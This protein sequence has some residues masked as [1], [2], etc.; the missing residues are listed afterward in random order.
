VVNSLGDAGMGSGAQGDLRYAITQANAHPGSTIEFDVS[1]SIQLTSALPAMTASMNIDGPGPG[2]LTVHGKAAPAS[3]SVFAVSAGVDVSISGL[4]ITGGNAAEGGG[5]NNAGTLTVNNSV[6]AGNTATTDGGAIS[7]SGTLTLVRSALTGN[8]APAGGALANTAG[9]ASLSYDTLSSNSATT[10]GGAIANSA[11]MSVLDST[12]ASNSSG[13]GGGAIQN[14]ATLLLTNSTVWGNTAADKGGGIVNQS[15]N[16]T[17]T[18]DTLSANRATNGFGGGLEDLGAA[19]LLNNTLIA[20]NLAGSSPSTTAGDVDG[21]VNSASSSNLIGDGDHLTGISNGSQGNQIGSASAGTVINARLVPLAGNGG[22][23]TTAA[24]LPTSPALG[25]GSVA[26]AVEPNTGLSLTTDQRGLGF[27]RVVNG[28]VDIGAYESGL[29]SPSGT[30]YTVNSLGDTGSGSGTSGDLRYAITQA[31]ANPGSTI[32]FSV[33]GTIALSSLLPALSAD[34][35]IAGPG[36]TRLTVDGV[37]NAPAT[38]GVFTINA[39][40]SASISNLAIAGLPTGT[41]GSTG[42]DIANAGT[43]VLTNSTLTGTVSPARAALYNT[44]TANATLRNVSITGNH[45][46]SILS[47]GALT[48]LNSSVTGD[49]FTFSGSGNG[50][51][52]YITRGQLTMDGST[53]SGNSVTPNHAEYYHN[54]IRVNQ[55]S[56]TLTNCTI[57]GNSSNASYGYAVSAGYGAQVS[58]T[59]VTIAGNA[60]GGCLSTAVVRLSNATISGN[61]GPGLMIDRGYYLSY[62]VGDVHV[63]LANSLLSG[64]VTKKNSIQKDVVGVVDPK[65]SGNLIASGYATGITNGS[66]GNQIGSQKQGTIINPDLG[67][68]TN[69]GGA[70]QT[71]ALLA[72]S[73]AIDSGLNSAVT[74]TTDS[75][76]TSDQ[77]GPGFSRIVHDTIDI[78][79]YEFQASPT[80]A[81]RLVSLVPVSSSV[82]VNNTFTLVVSAE[83]S[84]GAV[85]VGIVGSVALAL[86]NNPSGAHLGGNLTANFVNGEAVFIGLT[87]DQPGSGY[88]IVASSGGLASAT[89]NAFDV[90]TV[91]ATKLVITVPPPTPIVAGV[92]FNMSVAAEDGLG[93]IDTS[94]DG[95]VSVRAD[96]SDPLMNGNPVYGKTTVAVVNGIAN[97]TGLT[98][99]WANGYGGLDPNTINATSAGLVSAYVDHLDVVPGAATQLVVQ[100]QPPSTVTSEARFGLTVLA[101]DSVGNVDTSFSGNVSIAIASNPS[102]GTLGGTVVVAAANG[103]AVFASSAQQGLY[104]DK[105][106]AGYTLQATSPGLTPVTTS[107]IT[108]NPGAAIRLVTTAEPPAAVNVGQTFG[109][110]VTAEDAGGNPI[111]GYSGFVTVAIANNPGGAILGG[112]VKE[113]AVNGVA[114]FTDLTLDQQGFGY[115]LTASSSGLTSN[116]TSAFDVLGPHTPPTA[117]PQT[118]TLPDSGSA[119]ITLTGSSPVT[120][121]SELVYTLTSLPASGTLY[122]SDGN[123]AFVGETFT[124]SA[125]VL[126]YIL[127]TEVLGD[128]STSF[129]FT[130]T[131][132]GEP[133]G[134]MNTLTSSPA[135]VTIQTPASSTGI[136][137]VFGGPGNDTIVLSQTSGNTNLHVLVNG[138]A[139]GSD[140]PF[141]SVTSIEVTGRDGTNSYTIPAGLPAPISVIGGTGADTLIAGA[142]NLTFNGG[143][144]GDA[145][146]VTLD[147]NA[148]TTTLSPTS[149][150]IT[151]GSDTIT[152]SNVATITVNGNNNATATLNDSPGN[153]TFTASPTFGTMTGPGF[154][155]RANGFAGVTA[156]S[157]AGGSDSAHLSD[158]SGSNTFTATPA[159]ATFSGTGFSESARGFGA[160]YGTAAAGTTDTAT[161]SDA[162]GSNS[163]TGTPTYG[164]FYGTGFYNKGTGFVSVLAKAAAGTADTATLNDS[165]GNDTFTATPT[166]GTMT[167]PGYSNRANGFASLTAISSAGG[168]D[169]AHLS[170]TSGRNTFTATPTSATFGGT[171]FS[172][173]AK[174]FGAVYGTAAAGTTDTATL[175]DVSGTN[176]F[177]GTPTYGLFDGAGFYDKASGF[178]EVLAKAAA[179]TTDTATLSDTSGTNLLSADPDLVWL[180]GS[181][182]FNT[183]SR[184]SSVVANSAAGTT[185]SAYLDDS[186]GNDTFTATPTSA[187]MTGPGYWNRANGFKSSAAFSRRGGTDSAHLSDTSGRNTFTAYPTYALFSGNGFSEEANGFVTVYGTATAGTTDT[188]TL[189]DW[190]GSN[191]FAGTPTSGLFYGT[192]F[193]IKAAGFV[194]VRATAV[195]GTTDSATLNDSSG[196]D[197][198]TAGPTSATMTGPGYSNLAIGFKS[199]TAISSAGGT[200]SAHLSDK[201]GS[202]TFTATPTTATFS[203]SGFSETAKGF[204]AMYGTAAAGTTDTATLSDASGS[205]T[206][207]GTPTSGLFYGTGFYNK[208]AG[209]VSVVA[210][211]AAGTTDSA[212]LNDSSGNDTFTAGPTFGTMTGPGYSNRANG[213]AS[214][215]AVSSAGGTDSAHLSDTSG[216]N[217]FTATQ[218]SATFRGTGFA[219]TAKGFGAVYGTAAAGTTDTASLTDSSGS[220]IFTGTPTSGLFYGTGFYNKASGFVTV[221]ATAAHNSDVANLSDD[222]AGAQFNGTGKVGTLAGPTYTLNVTAYGTVNITGAS[223]ASNKV[224]TA[225]IDYVLNKIGTWTAD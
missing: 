26:L 140:V 143:G 50:G 106:G 88:T 3:F 85:D 201:S 197:T 139:P 16:L 222:A 219:L 196:N 60:E 121:G 107:S 127:P 74:L 179:G 61:Q 177:T 41:S 51:N 98:M 63:L 64:N 202:N 71:Q 176:T 191:H 169:S 68:L 4:T 133:D 6:L 81:T 138:N 89:T 117:N 172:N 186:S 209:F 96:N 221:S 187:T 111:A 97:F 102:G 52:I 182:Y 92:G 216:S 13:G 198:F 27:A 199:V 183:V 118:V 124:G 83:D 58:M 14:S 37:P 36:A 93:H 155:E 44:D 5:I 59:N 152:L 151:D 218:T 10:T 135:T 131:D 22:P 94:Y 65:S 40:V 212:T 184:F 203:G 32:V 112:T 165:S 147:A 87:V 200:D 34:V 126:T 105:A 110:E 194:S 19:A 213:F 8:S 166:F 214:V 206:F 77:R 204:G 154:S 137:R 47:A 55:G 103:V 30:V 73:P 171:R 84:T 170:D 53:V 181:G 188:A 35:T 72:A 38:G 1:G 136:L 17:L 146:T 168:T 125:A 175:S 174:G 114:T 9:T 67:P 28:A 24:L 163:F 2:T 144:G 20:S 119:S 192:G 31:N 21:P 76:P 149:A 91:T 70:T 29:Q 223:G 48:L 54:A 208:A 43:L 158:M 189:S 39:G 224:H 56:A 195:A 33:T 180:S 116:T 178:V 79:S 156:I 132:N 193:Y 190:G 207:T 130:V 25:A 167:G 18:N 108:V 162:S 225:A 173:T 217:T 141:S 211:A 113:P 129:T 11:S 120:P 115:T 215:T 66:Q 145:A 123:A 45:A 142:N 95:T 99:N 86:G 157:S 134:A 148:G 109:L 128:L 82:G 46:R 150:A 159:T 7:N 122:Q 161:L 75:P 205:N 160:V 220:N 57:S 100:T 101:E 42:P 80:Q 210:K 78:G 69:N 12:L 62:S 104:L 153:D 185:D 15:A 23:T 49:S 90:V 164:L